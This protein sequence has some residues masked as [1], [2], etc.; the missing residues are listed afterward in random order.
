[1]GRNTRP[2]P[3]PAPMAQSSGTRPPGA[4]P[5]PGAQPAAQ[6]G[7]ARP[8]P[9]NPD[10]YGASFSGDT[11]NRIRVTQ[12]AENK[13][14]VS[15]YKGDDLIYDHDTDEVYHDAKS[16]RLAWRDMN[17]GRTNAIGTRQGSSDYD[18]RPGGHGFG[19]GGSDRLKPPTWASHLADGWLRE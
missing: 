8:M 7:P 15:Q 3:A 1:M 4:H 11:G 14:T 13:F 5:R 12:K 17:S 10:W 19:K 9:N 6:S 2:S 18:N 16:G